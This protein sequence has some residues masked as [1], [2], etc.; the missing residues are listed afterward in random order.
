MN[1]LVENTYKALDFYER[2]LLSES[3]LLNLIES[4]LIDIEMLD[5]GFV[6]SLKS[7]AKKVGHVLKRTAQIGTAAG[8]IGG[9]AFGG[10]A[11]YK[12]ADLHN[13]LIKAKNNYTQVIDKKYDD[14]K[15]KKDGNNVEE[16]KEK[17]FNHYNKKINMHQTS[18]DNQNKEVEKSRNFVNNQWVKSNADFVNSANEQ[19]KHNNEKNKTLLDGHNEN[20]KRIWGDAY[21]NGDLI[22]T[23]INLG[24]TEYNK[25]LAKKH[26]DENRL[27]SA[28]NEQNEHVKAMS[29][30]QKTTDQAIKQNEDM[31]NEIENLK[32]YGSKDKLYS[33]YN[34]H[35][36]KIDVA[37]RLIKGNQ[38]EIDK[39]NK[40]KNDVNLAKKEY[41]KAKDNYNNTIPGKVHKAYTKTKE[42]GKGL[43][44]AVFSN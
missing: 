39:I 26:G 35:K 40:E 8:L 44:H 16:N 13:D 31:N 34:H 36:S 4:G 32:K 5:E 38:N 41:D 30:S 15:L 23:F 29:Q 22:K 2:G 12:G 20:V 42:L 3:E 7:G 18:I 33:L 17:L 9:A 11:L 6:N 19:Q 25:A 27:K 24:K 10:S 37:D 21:K 1:L 43:Y 28:E 14:I